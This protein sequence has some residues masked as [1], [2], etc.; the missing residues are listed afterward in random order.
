MEKLNFQ[1]YH[2]DDFP[3]TYMKDI[4]LSIKRWCLKLAVGETD[5]KFRFLTSV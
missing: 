1:G 2:F 4:K 3:P 5:L